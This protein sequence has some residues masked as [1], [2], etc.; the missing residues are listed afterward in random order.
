MKK[1]PEINVGF[2]ELYRVL[3]APIKSKLLLTGIELYRSLTSEYKGC[4]F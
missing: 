2:E 1:L 4:Y 3:V